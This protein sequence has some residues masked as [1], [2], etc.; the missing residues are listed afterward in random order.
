MFRWQGAVTPWSPSAVHDSVAAIAR[1]AEY[2]RSLSTT[3]WQQ[4]WNWF[5]RL[6]GE[7]FDLFRG[8]A[9]GRNV[10]AALVALLAVLVI[11]RFVIAARAAREEAGPRDVRT[12]RR[13]TTDAWTD[14]ERFAAAGR[15]TEAAHALLAALLSAFAAR[16]E[17]R[18]H[19]S[20]TAGDYARELQ[21]RGSTAQHDFFAFRKRYD[22]VIYGVGACSAD[23][24]A[25]LLSD[26]RPLLGL[27]YAA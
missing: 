17:V 24:Y 15:F 5:N 18:L 9:A 7:F 6:V 27:P 3:L 23:E 12:A 4:F 25:A 13:G 19:A 21:R 11:A 26:A 14:A 1:Q 20:K 22:G 8:S 10:T 2:Q 16:G